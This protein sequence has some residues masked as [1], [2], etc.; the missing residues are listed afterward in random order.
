MPTSPGLLENTGEVEI[1]VRG[2]WFQT[3]LFKC[4]IL[5][6]TSETFHRPHG[7]LDMDQEQR[8][9]SKGV[10][11]IQNGVRFAEFGSR[12]RRSLSQQE[13][14]VR[15]LQRATQELGNGI[16]TGR[17]L[18]S[19]NMHISRLL[20]LTPLSTMSHEWFMALALT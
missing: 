7:G 17:F 1:T 10:F 3:T 9:Y 19:S 18:G 2:K 8:A 16:E 15:G 6:A 14:V 11:C 5:Q 13:C 12:R 20:G 4:P